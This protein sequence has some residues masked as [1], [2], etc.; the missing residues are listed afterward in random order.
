M[1][2]IF[3]NL[4]ILVLTFHSCEIDNFE[5]PDASL[6]GEIVDPNGKRLE[7]EQGQG[8]ARIR[9][10]DFGFTETPVPFYLNF[11]MDGTYINTKVF[12]SKYYIT[13]I[14]GPFF[15]VLGD[16]VEVVG[17]T[18]HNFTV[19]PYLDVEW[20]GDPQ[21]TAD[22]KVVANFKFKRNEPSAGA[23]KPDVLD[24]QL[25]IST[26]KYVGNN[27]SVSNGQPTSVGNAAE[28]TSLSITSQN[29]MKYATT[30]YVRVGVRVDDSFKKYNYSSVKTVQIPE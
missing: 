1:K 2:K 26:T 6:Q 21:V 29:P 19:I 30:Y 25:F 10:E 14:D 28:G 23:A 8:S 13:P 11:K 12:A 24:Y 4:M 3:F 22:K 5:G 16:T 17:N 18:T 7:L 15:P 20:D 9:M 27:N